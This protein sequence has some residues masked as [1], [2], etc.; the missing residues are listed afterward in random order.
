MAAVAWC[1]AA[2]ASNNQNSSMGNSSS[3]LPTS[4]ISSPS[5]SSSSSSTNQSPIQ[6]SQYAANF[7]YQNQHQFQSGSSNT[8]L[9]TNASPLTNF[10][11]SYNPFVSTQNNL[12]INSTGNLYPQVVNNSSPNVNTGVNDHRTSSIAALRLKAREHSVALGT[13]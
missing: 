8:N 6:Q 5:F 13:I 2:A 10:M 3:S 7:Q 1:A 11:A 9:F 12:L 4:S